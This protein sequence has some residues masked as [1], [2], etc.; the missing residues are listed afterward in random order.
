MGHP[1]FHLE[2]QVRSCEAELRLNGF[3]VIPKLSS[4]NA[5]PVS[6][7]PPVNPYLAGARNT[8]ELTLRPAVAA[9][10]SEAPFGRADFE[11]NMRRF[12]E[13]DIVEPGAGEM[14]TV[15]TLSDELRERIR[16]GERKP[17]VIISHAF[18]NDV[19]DFSAELLDAA[20]FKDAGAVADYALHLRD[21]MAVGDVDAL[22]AEYEPK[23]RVGV[24]AYGNSYEERRDNTREGLAKFVRNAPELDFDRSDLDV[25]P[26]CGGRIWGLLR[27]GGLPFAR[28]NGGRTR[29]VIYVAPRDGTLRVVR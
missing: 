22:V 25:Q 4:P 20:P 28:S 19:L 12:E 14:V 26:H 6:F 24:A 11:M 15:L 2:L 7:A 5:L 9:D 1:L 27:R 16:K 21:L 13:G 17:P 18:A 8:V 3:P 10:G 23:I 29:C